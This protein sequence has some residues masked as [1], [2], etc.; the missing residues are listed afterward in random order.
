MAYLP[1]WDEP[2]SFSTLVV[3]TT[4]D[5]GAMRG[6]VTAVIRGLDPALPPKN[7]PSMDAVLASA[8]AS[9]QFQLEFG[10][11]GAPPRGACMEWCPRPSSD[12]AASLLLILRWP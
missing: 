4:A 10:T 6:P 8:L 5:R 7:V 12:G 2:Q 1:C 9:R 11:A 3:Q